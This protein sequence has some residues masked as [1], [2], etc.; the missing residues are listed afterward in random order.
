MYMDNKKLKNIIKESILAELGED[1]SKFKATIEWVQDRYNKANQE[2]FNGRLGACNF[3]IADLGVRTNGR[4]TLDTP[5]NYLYYDPKANNHL[6]VVPYIGASR[7]YINKEN[8][9]KY[10]NPTILLNSNR[11]ATEESRYTTLVHE[12]CHYYTYMF[13]FV[14]KQAHGRE[15]RDI[16][17]IIAY[18]SNGAITVQRLASA[19]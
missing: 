9:V 1:G 19:E 18:R 7:I 17:S 5:S 11:S 13:G 4:F 16:A 3:K 12:M 10:C 8:F 2:L 14:P 15:F 6:Y